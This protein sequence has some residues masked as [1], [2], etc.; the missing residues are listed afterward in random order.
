MNLKTDNLP[1]AIEKY[2]Q[3]LLPDVQPIVDDIESKPATTKGN[4]GRYMAALSRLGTD[5]NSMILVAVTMI[6][7]GGNKY[8]I[9][10]ALKICRGDA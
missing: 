10:S 7:A 5:K 1:P 6:R 3:S 9:T 8:G 4:Y 2:I